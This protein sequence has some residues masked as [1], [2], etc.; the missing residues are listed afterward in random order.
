MFKKRHKWELVVEILKLKGDISYAEMKREFTESHHPDGAP[1]TNEVSDST[2]ARGRQAWVDEG[3]PREKS[4]IRPIKYD[5]I[6]IHAVAWS[7]GPF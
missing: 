4:R 5:H 6:P 2:I 3:C 1:G 7:T